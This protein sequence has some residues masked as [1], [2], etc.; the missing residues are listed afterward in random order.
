MESKDTKLIHG[1]RG[2]GLMLLDCSPNIPYTMPN[3]NLMKYNPGSQNHEQGSLSVFP[4][5]ELATNELARRLGGGG[6]VARSG[7]LCIVA[8]SVSGRDNYQHRIYCRHQGRNWRVGA[9]H[10]W[11]RYSRV[12]LRAWACCSDNSRRAY[13]SEFLVTTAPS[14]GWFII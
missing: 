5:H 12:K 1:S 7:L 9:E 13:I 11:S 4:T 8:I 3:N 2:A 6:C 10:T 14:L